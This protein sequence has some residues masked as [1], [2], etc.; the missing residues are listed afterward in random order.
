MKLFL[1]TSLIII[2]VLTVRADIDFI[3]NDYKKAFK[4][5]EKLDKLIFVDVYTDWC[6]PCKLMDKTVFKDRQVSKF[7][8]QKFVN[9]KINA[10]KGL[11]AKFAKEYNTEVYPTYYFLDKEGTII[12]TSRGGKN[13]DDFLKLGEMA[14]D[15]NYQPS[16]MIVAFESGKNDKK[17]LD[18]CLMVFKDNLKIDYSGRI[19]DSYLKSGYFKNEE[20]MLEMAE[21]YLF[22]LDNKL[23]EE[24][25][26]LGREN[27]EKTNYLSVTVNRIINNYIFYDNSLSKEEL[28]NIL[29]KSILDE[30]TR[31][32]LSK[33]AEIMNKI[34]FGPQ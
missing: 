22:T 19:L 27:P 31:V 4:E 20:E 16:K 23:F 34:K 21:K 14:I 2:S 25:N 7:Y 29:S 28:D 13:T 24:L 15:P 32:K 26:A 33:K 8:N 10:E 5:A 18:E 3:K 6:G 11:G 12:Y 9:L 17:F 30:Q 1:I